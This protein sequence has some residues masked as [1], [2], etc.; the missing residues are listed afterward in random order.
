VGAAALI[1]LPML[2]RE[3]IVFKFG[4]V[5]IFFVAAIGL[6]VLVNWAG[7]LSL[8]H[9]AM[10]G[11]PAFAVLTI[12]SNAG[13]S[14]IYLLPVAVLLGAVVGG[15][16]ALPTL[17]AKDL[18]VALV[19]LI[20]GIGIDRFFFAQQWLVGGA[21]GRASA[22]PTLGPLRFTTNRSLYPVLAVVVLAAIAAAWAMMHSKFARAWFWIR[23]DP[24]AAS[25][26]GI[27]VVAYRIGVYAIGGAFAGLAGGMTVMWIQRLG[28]NA[29]P[30]TLS[31]AYLLI[32]VLAGPG[33]LGGLAVATL[34]LQG[35]QQFAANI[36][37][38][39]GGKTIDT[40]LT[41]GGPLGLIAVIAQYQEGFNGLGRRLMHRIKA[42]APPG[43]DAAEDRSVRLAELFSVG[44]VVGVAAIVAGFVAM[45]LAWHH[46]SRTDQLWVQNQEIL[47]GGL[48][49]LGLI[50][51][52]VGLLIRDR[53]ARNN[54][55]L[56]RQL[57]E[58]V[59]NGQ[60][61]PDDP[62][63]P[64][65]IAEGTSEARGVGRRARPT[66]QAGE[67]PADPTVPFAPDDPA[68][69]VLPDDTPSRSNGRQRR[70]RVG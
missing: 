37:G 24:D 10:V 16:V 40:I 5:L 23:A 48:A 70:S 64:A 6:H 7:Q 36:F 52:G 63:T 67:A 50:L 58:L 35:G 31:F 60:T 43:S 21:G 17:R 59:L 47:S 65:E 61:S 28:D 44:A 33:F 38:T 46:I 30:D 1:L 69:A 49:G 53:L 9:T 32:A 15:V 42:D 4:V 20:A 68:G 13:I 8:A 3:V 66:G 19:T 22:I 57:A 55:L 51:V 29:F 11:V 27:P 62:S 2:G 26:F 54:M 45:A 25:A 12:S 18:Q 14:P 39:G 41:Y 56:A 34:M